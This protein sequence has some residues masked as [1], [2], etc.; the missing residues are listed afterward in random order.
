MP[1]QI[2]GGFIDLY[3]TGMVDERNG[4]IV[5]ITVK[6]CIAVGT[7][8]SNLV[9]VLV[10]DVAGDRCVVLKENMSVVES[11]GGIK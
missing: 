9:N 5:E 1:E 4:E 11:V 8:I 7:I 3:K 10:V 2:K 6:G